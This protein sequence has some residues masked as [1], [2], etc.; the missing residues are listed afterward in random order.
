MRNLP[1][2][3]K[4]DVEG[5]GQHPQEFHIEKL[6]HPDCHL[7]AGFYEAPYPA[8]QLTSVC[9]VLLM[10]WS[11]I[12]RYITTI[13]AYT[14]LAFLKSQQ[15]YVTPGRGSDFSLCHHIQNDLGVDA[16]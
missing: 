5:G 2:H 15:W 3:V 13:S 4:N 14:L 12:C 16:Y 1:P 7:V 9:T 6:A 10:N 11:V 8:T